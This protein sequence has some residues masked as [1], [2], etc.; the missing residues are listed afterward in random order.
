MKGNFRRLQTLLPFS[1]SATRCPAP[2]SHYFLVIGRN[3]N[4][5]KQPPKKPNR[6]KFSPSLLPAC[7]SSLSK[8]GWGWIAPGCILP[9]PAEAGRKLGAARSA[10]SLAVCVRVHAHVSSAPGPGTGTA[11][12][13]VSP[14]AQLWGLAALG[15][16]GDAGA[17]AERPAA[18]TPGRFALP[19]PAPSPPSFPGEQVS[20]G[21]SS[22][23]SPPPRS[24]PCPHPPR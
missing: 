2:Y 1:Q 11:P 12:G 24:A 10:S 4:K 3:G 18:R 15:E 9:R 22:Y 21:T 20:L 7:S 23:P 19:P 5:T 8:Q 14:T 13:I 6:G 16:G 17:A